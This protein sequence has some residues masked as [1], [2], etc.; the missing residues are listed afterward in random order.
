MGLNRWKDSPKELHKQGHWIM[1]LS[2]WSGMNANCARGGWFGDTWNDVTVTSEWGYKMAGHP[3]NHHSITS[4]QLQLA[5]GSQSVKKR[6]QLT[7]F[8]SQKARLGLL[9]CC[10]WT[11]QIWI[12]MEKPQKKENN[13]K[14]LII[15]VKNI[16]KSSLHS[17]NIKI[18]LLF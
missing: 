2:A 10:N 3:L 12:K 4:I 18:I 16:K 5:D 17:L 9:Y 7:T 13:I 11:F 1:D 8:F 15:F 6:W 14:M